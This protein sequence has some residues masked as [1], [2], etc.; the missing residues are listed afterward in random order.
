MNIYLS[1]E[2]QNNDCIDCYNKDSHHK[3]KYVI[4]NKPYKRKPHGVYK[5]FVVCDENKNPK[6]Y[7]YSM[8]DNS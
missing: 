1:L 5:S 4:R 2:N 7:V 8:E 6:L 3:I